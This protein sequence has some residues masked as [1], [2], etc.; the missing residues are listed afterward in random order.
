MM[1]PVLGHVWVK[2]FV[3][4]NIM[5]K[6]FYWCSSN[7]WIFGKK[8]TKK[9]YCQGGAISFGFFLILGATP[10]QLYI[11]LRWTNVCFEIRALLFEIWDA[12]KLVHVLSYTTTLLVALASCLLTPILW[13]QSTLLLLLFSSTFFSLSSLSFLFLFLLNNHVKL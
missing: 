4:T 10:H 11:V 1:L 13:E 2:K 7:K 9:C 3:I 5:G 12:L 6:E 8:K